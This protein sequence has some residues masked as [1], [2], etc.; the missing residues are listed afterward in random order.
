M[1]GMNIPSRSSM[2]TL[3][4]ITRI[5]DVGARLGLGIAARGVTGGLAGGIGGLGDGGELSNT[6]LID[7]QIEMQ[8]E[9]LA[10]NLQ[11]NTLR[12]DHEAKMSCVRN[13]KP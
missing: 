1:S 9:T 11:S 4:A 7:K 10:I 2:E 8:R 5:A 3:G 13:L 6:E 12:T